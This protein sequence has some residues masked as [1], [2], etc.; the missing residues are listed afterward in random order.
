MIV[1]QSCYDIREENLLNFFFFC[2]N[3]KIS[4]NLW[5]SAV[6]IYT[7]IY[8]FAIIS[9]EQ[10][11]AG[12]KWNAHTSLHTH[13]HTH[14]H[15]PYLV[16]FLING[17]SGVRLLHVWQLLGARW[18]VQKFLYIILVNKSLNSLISIFSI[19]FICVVW[20]K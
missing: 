3:I 8:N 16:L 11:Q 19:F 13:T 7:Y 14:T 4:S 12:H 6:Q 15:T 10:V 18:L 5:L 1:L 20:N 2:F 9:K 17:P